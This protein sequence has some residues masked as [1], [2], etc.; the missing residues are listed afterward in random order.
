MKRKKI[1]IGLISILIVSLM[2]TGCGKKI[3]VKNGSKVAVSVTKNKFT[4]TEYYEKIKGKNISTL[5]DMIDHS[6][7]DKEYKTDDKETDSINSQIDQIKQYY[8]ENEES[9]LQI[10][11]Q[12]FG[13]DDENQLREIL[14]LEYKRNLAVEDYI[15]DNLKEDEK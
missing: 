13:A 4:A 5:I 2:I 10:L 11:K 1:I 3:E 8:G 15:K 7:L 12:Y 14:S 6:L 9:Y